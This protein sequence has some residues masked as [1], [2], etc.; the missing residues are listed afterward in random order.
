MGDRG[1]ALIFVEEPEQVPVAINVARQEGGQLLALSPAVQYEIERAGMPLRIPEDFHTEE[2]IDAIGWKD[3]ELLDFLESE[4]DPVIAE[5]VP[6]FQELR[7]GPIALSWYEWKLLL[8]P[9]SIRVFIVARLLK[10]LRP[11][12]VRYF[13][14]TPYRY[15]WSRGASFGSPWPVVIA[16]VCQ[17]FGISAGSI[18]LREKERVARTR[19]IGRAFAARV[20]RTSSELACAIKALRVWRKNNSCGDRLIVLSRGY[21]VEPLMAEARRQRSFEMWFWRSDRA[22][23]QEAR[24]TSERGRSIKVEAQSVLRRNLWKLVRR[25]T[26]ICSEFEREG[27][28]LTD[29]LQRPLEAFFNETVFHAAQQYSS[30]LSVIEKAKP[31]AFL[32]SICLWPE[33]IVAQTARLAKVPFIVYRHGP[34]DGYFWH[35]GYSDPVSYQ[36]EGRWAS[37]M[38]VFGDHDRSCIERWWGGRGSLEAVPVGSAA[39]DELRE[40]VRGVGARERAIALMGLKSDRPVVMYVL[41]GLDGAGRYAPYRA[42]SP[43]RVFALQ[44]RILEVFARFPLVQ[45]VLKL[46]PGTENQNG[47]PPL[48]EVVCDRGYAN[49]FIETRRLTDVIAGADAFVFDDLSTAFLEALTTDRAIFLCKEGLPG[50]AGAAGWSPKRRSS[51]R[52]RVV[53]VERV[54]ALVGELERWL[55]GNDDGPADDGLLRELGTYQNDGQSAER[56]HDAVRQIAAIGRGRTTSARTGDTR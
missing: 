50:S 44:R 56:A 41:T 22:G 17:A 38:L 26:S 45:F 25:E 54:E 39:L 4:V 32:A 53:Y 28:S 31:A 42:V 35:E 14:A 6:E 12:I 34:L 2:E 10:E 18:D 37:H 5:Y 29:V 49:C 24:L 19:N 52:R 55:V 40:R 27:V 20:R 23:F 46:F 43:G 15:Q 8:N 3:I 11:S 7:A 13:S 21:S 47:V 1:G 9:F 48:R 16:S 30:A 36:N 33:R 51:W